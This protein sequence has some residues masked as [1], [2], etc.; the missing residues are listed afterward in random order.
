MREEARIARDRG[1][2]RF[3]IVTSGPRLTRDEIGRVGDGVHEIV[4]TGMRAC[5][6]LGSIGRE[7][8]EFLKSA[9]LS[10]YHHNIETAESFYP[11]IVRTH[12]Y[13]SRIATIQDAQKTGL[14]VCSGGIFGMGE[15]L[16]DRIA[17][18]HALR[19][20][21]VDAVPVN[22]LVPVRGT[23]LE[24]IEP[25]PA[26]EILRT[27]A[28]FRLILGKTTIILA[29]GRDRFDVRQAFDS[30]VN[31]IMIGDYL[32]TKGCDAQRDRAMIREVE[33]SWQAGI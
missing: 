33:A 10:R 16:S 2:E 5:A 15:S 30:G 20:L 18:A 26:Q 19:V 21:N 1:A 14:E 32:T 13:M 29:A 7:D 31:G 22:V 4:K 12:T 11:R 6:S 23:P 8:L 25:L 17:M 9:G 24:N 3:S 27:L 28:L